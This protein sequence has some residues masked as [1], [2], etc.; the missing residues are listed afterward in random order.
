MGARMAR[1]LRSSRG[2]HIGGRAN[3]IRGREKSDE[4]RATSDA[5]FRECGD[6]G[7][8]GVGGGFV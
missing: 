1:P 3:P 7:A 6:E 5:V 4:L 2:T 8:N